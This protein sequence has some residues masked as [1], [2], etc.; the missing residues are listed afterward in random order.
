MRYLS[1]RTG[2]LYV[3]IPFV[4]ILAYFLDSTDQNDTARPID[5]LLFDLHSRKNIPG[6][7]YRS[8]DVECENERGV[9][10]M[11]LKLRGKLILSIGILIFLAVFLLSLLSNISLRIAYDKVIVAE[12]EKLDQIIQSQVECMIG[13]LDRKSVV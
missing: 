2:S 13:V 3:K 7:L 10:G 6:S 11:K 9:F 4:S 5:S 12:K 1:K 8:K